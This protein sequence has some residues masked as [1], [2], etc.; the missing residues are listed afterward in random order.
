MLKCCISCYFVVKLSLCMSVYRYIMIIRIRTPQTT[1]LCWMF[2]FLQSS[3]F[4]PALFRVGKGW[5][6]TAPRWWCQLST[7]QTWPP[8]WRTPRR[9]F[10]CPL[11]PSPPLTGPPNW[12]WVCA[13]TVSV[14]LF[15]SHYVFHETTCLCLSSFL[16]TFS[17]SVTVMCGN[18]L[19]I[20]GCPF[21]WLT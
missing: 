4:F 8:S 21:L 9:W 12:K 17:E 5:C 20:Q 7:Q 3:V 15:S 2:L 10:R 19:Q 16:G 6:P 11:A 18:C 13:V 14:E 1:P